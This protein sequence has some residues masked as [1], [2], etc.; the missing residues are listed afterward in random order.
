MKNDN[1]KIISVLATKELDRRIIELSK[2]YNCSK[3]KMI[4]VLLSFSLQESDKEELILFLNK[5]LR[6]F[7]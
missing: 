4:N 5:K 7:Y 3:S 2:K 6:I 1:K